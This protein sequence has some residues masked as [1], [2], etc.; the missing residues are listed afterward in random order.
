MLAMEA[1]E[2]PITQVTS[3]CFMV[4]SGH[5]FEG[6]TATYHQIVDVPTTQI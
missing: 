4:A 1:R 2:G 5:P 6:M 3:V